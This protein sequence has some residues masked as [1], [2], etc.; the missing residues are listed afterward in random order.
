MWSSDN[1][2]VSGSS[3]QVDD[4]PRTRILVVDD[5]DLFRSGLSSL[6]AREYGFEVIAQASNG[7]MAIRLARELRPEVVLMDLNMPRVSGE[8][9]TRAI[10]AQDPD[11]RVVMLTVADDEAA[12][13]RSIRAGADGFVL[14]DS[15]IGDVA[16]AI[17]AVARRRPWLSPSAAG[18]LLERVRREPE[19]P[20]HD[21]VAFSRLT[22]R[23]RE[24]LRLL[25]AGA[26]NAEI[27]VRLGISNRTAKN[28]VSSVLAKLE[29]NNRVQAAVFATRHGIE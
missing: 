23:E 25:V 29:L 22:Q 11:V 16:A 2:V 18:R 17:R 24:V 20:E 3:D 28:H 26:E 8:D 4:L 10:T 13:A 12:V 6:L 9:A 19:E 27:A 7:T 5:H 14:K 15:P 1:G 21:D